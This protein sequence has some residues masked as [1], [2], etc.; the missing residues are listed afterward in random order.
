MGSTLLQKLFT[1]ERP[2]GE[3]YGS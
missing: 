2:S 3:S 1:S